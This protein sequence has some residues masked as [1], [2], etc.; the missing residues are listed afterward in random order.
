ME[1]KILNYLQK[2]VI[3]SEKIKFVLRKLRVK[4][5]FWKIVWRPVFMFCILGLYSQIKS[6]LFLQI[7]KRLPMEVILRSVVLKG[8]FLLC[9]T[10]FS[11]QPSFL[12]NNVKHN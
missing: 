11:H 9:K 10:L 3:I 2:N 5:I 6:Y 12:S 1:K 4:Q 8:Y 7:Q